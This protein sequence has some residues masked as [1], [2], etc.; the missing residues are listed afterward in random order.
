MKSKQLMK[1]F[2]EF[3]TP[4]SIKAS[5]DPSEFQGEV[6]IKQVEYI[7]ININEENAEEIER[8]IGQISEIV[9]T[10]GAV[11]GEVCSSLITGYFGMLEGD[12]KGAVHRSKLTQE[13]LSSLGNKA[14]II[15]GSCSARV[16]SFGGGNS[17]R[18]CAI[19]PGFSTLLGKLL[20]LPFGSASEA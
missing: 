12:T 20:N 6:K 11:M 16:G 19:L 8:I 14:R 18:F 9:S 5:L 10:H 15:H 3:L 2:S 4:D 17:W 1:K 13:L 7:L